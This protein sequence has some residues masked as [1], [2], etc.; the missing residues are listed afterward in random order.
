MS[1]DFRMIVDAGGETPG[2]VFDDLNYTYNVSPMYYDAFDGNKGVNILQGKTGEEC[3][4][5]LETAIKK[6]KA[7]PEKY[8]KLNP[9]NGWGDYSGALR[10]L[11][12][13]LMWCQEAPKANMDIC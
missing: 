3:I 2:I 6:F 4:P 13:L 11:E 7:D 10:V 8:Q 12:E 9:K 1:Y 5:W